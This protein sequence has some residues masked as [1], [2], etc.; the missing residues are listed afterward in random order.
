M[1]ACEHVI[2]RGLNIIGYIYMLGLN[3]RLAGVNFAVI[4]NFVGQEA[5]WYI[6]HFQIKTHIRTRPQFRFLSEI[7][8]AFAS[9]WQ[10]GISSC[11][12]GLTTWSYGIYFFLN[13]T[14]TLLLDIVDSSARALGCCPRTLHHSRHSWDLAPRLPHVMSQNIPSSGFHSK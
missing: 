3:P 7:F 6:H 4:H 10:H 9:L 8:Q 11:S 13:M 2:W 5:S 12:P 1:R 14:L